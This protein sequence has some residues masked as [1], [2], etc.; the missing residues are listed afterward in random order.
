[1]GKKKKNKTPAARLE[2]DKSMRK[3]MD[4]PDNA[5]LGMNMFSYT[6][7]PDFSYVLLPATRLCYSPDEN[8][9]IDV[10]AICENFG[11]SDLN[12]KWK[13]TELNS[14]DS[15]GKEYENTTKAPYVAI[16]SLNNIANDHRI[17]ISVTVED[18]GNPVKTVDAGKMI[19]KPV[20]TP[21][22]ITDKVEWFSVQD[23]VKMKANSEL[24]KMVCSVIELYGYNGEDVTVDRFVTFNGGVIFSNLDKLVASNNCLLVKFNRSEIAGKAKTGDTVTLNYT[25]QARTGESSD[26]IKHDFKLAERT[27]VKEEAA[28]ALQP[29]VCGP[30]DIRENN[31]KQCKYTKIEAEYAKDPKGT[32][33]EKITVFQENDNIEALPINLIGGKRKVDIVLSDYTPDKCRL[34]EGSHKSDNKAILKGYNIKEEPLDIS[35]SKITRE[36][37]YDYPKNKLLSSYL[38][39]GKDNVRE[40]TLQL[41]TCRYTKIVPINLYPDIEWELAL[42]VALDSP[43]AYTSS[44]K[45]PDANNSS[46]S[47]SNARYKEAHKKAIESGWAREA[48][49]RG[50][51]VD[52]EFELSLKSTIHRGGAK[53]VDEHAASMIANIQTFIK[54]VSTIKQLAEKVKG[55]SGGTVKKIPTV[56]SNPFSI[57]I[58]SPKV[59]A[60][61]SWKLENDNST[62]IVGCVGTVSVFAD[63]LIGA[64][65]TIDLIAAGTSAINPVIGK[66]VSW[67]RGGL[68]A[69]GGQFIIELKFYGKLDISLEGVTFNTATKQISMGGEQTISGKMG[70]ILNL[71]AKVGA[72]VKVV[73]TKPS[74]YFKAKAEADAFF[75]GD[76]TLNAS[77]DGGVYL[78][79]T[80]KFSGLLLSAAFEI[81]V[82]WWIFSYSKTLELEAE[83]LFE[84]EKGFNIGRARLI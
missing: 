16:S 43:A 32:E 29:V 1:M 77:S 57:E 67:C 54:V 80:G 13:Y 25:I 66:I 58:L 5:V 40:Y 46:L 12:F 31:F 79:I 75:G 60:M 27:L 71:E 59:G 68:A 30:V 8:I 39:C 41:S 49:K 50:E 3:R 78:D 33:K 81:E 21:K 82:Q 73:S 72:K 44:N 18:A 38:W 83:P 24:D 9:S 53:Q 19:I 36:F 10:N 6:P 20:I 15:T 26:I 61:V 69:L 28:D 7:L 65:F 35:G 17:L 48:A 76:F 45:K 51:G 63:P 4:E 47:K 55:K 37:E 23:G 34:K 84:A 11:D 52:Y 56:S 62:N 22:E 2:L 14:D 74:F 70:L 42:A 64:E